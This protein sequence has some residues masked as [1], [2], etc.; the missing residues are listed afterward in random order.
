MCFS[1]CQD[2]TGMKALAAVESPWQWPDAA[3]R[4]VTGRVQPLQLCCQA[5]SMVVAW[6]TLRAPRQQRHNTIVNHT[7][8]AARSIDP[9][10]SRVLAA[11]SG[12]PVGQFNHQERGSWECLTGRKKE[13][14]E[15]GSRT[16]VGAFGRN[17][18][19]ELKTSPIHRHTVQYHAV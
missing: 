12:G 4:N 5:L 7:M 15:V 10:W 1:L 2:S 3:I 18:N 17:Q 9:V 8:G 19:P 14:G 16:A 6:Q 11:V 13:R